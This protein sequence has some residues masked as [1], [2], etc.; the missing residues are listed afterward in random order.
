MTSK[1]MP[2]NSGCKVGC[3]L[4][5]Y[6]VI[7]DNVI[8]GILGGVQGMIHY[9][10]MQPGLTAQPGTTISPDVTQAPTSPDITHTTSSPNDG[11]GDQD[12]A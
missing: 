7:D 3:V 11:Y 8:A 12:T 6:S 2:I 10:W 5:C 1:S 9:Q 4:F